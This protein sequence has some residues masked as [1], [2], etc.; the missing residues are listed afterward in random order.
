MYSTT[1]CYFY[2]NVFV[3]YGC[4]LLPCSGLTKSVGGIQSHVM[5]DLIHDPSEQ[6][7]LPK[8]ESMRGNFACI[9]GLKKLIRSSV[10]LELD[11]LPAEVWKGLLVL[12]LIITVMDKPVRNLF[13][14]NQCMNPMEFLNSLIRAILCHQ[15]IHPTIP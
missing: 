8:A 15:S 10:G 12:Q 14:L 7:T 13:F 5:L 3:Q 1:V 4:L 6:T 11:N 9:M 2:H